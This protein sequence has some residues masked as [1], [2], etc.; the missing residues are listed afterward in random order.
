MAPWAAISPEVVSDPT[1]QFS[2]QP[3]VFTDDSPDPSVGS[4]IEMW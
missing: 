1:P 2:F 4:V 3:I